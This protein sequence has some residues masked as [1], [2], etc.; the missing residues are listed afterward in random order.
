MTPFATHA[1]ALPTPSH[2]QLPN[3][4]MIFMRRG[5]DVGL[6]AAALVQ[7]CA[8]VLLQVVLLFPH[9]FVLLARVFVPCELAG[10]LTQF[11][12]PVIDVS[13]LD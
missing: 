6:F 9:F 1:A 10:W 3:S 8:Y 2:G 11:A 12:D 7:A 4:T 5:R 13:Q